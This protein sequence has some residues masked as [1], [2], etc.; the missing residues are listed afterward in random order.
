MFFNRGLF[1]YRHPAS[2]LPVFSTMLSGS[3]GVA[4]G[5]LLSWHTFLVATGQGTIDFVEN[6]QEWKQARKEGRTWRNPYNQGF[7]KN[8][9]VRLPMHVSSHPNKTNQSVFDVDGNLWWI[10]WMLPTTK[11]KQGTGLYAVSGTQNGNV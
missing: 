11:R 7:T 9:K 3:I 4:V 1:L 2:V 5:A 6:F 8:F 10:R